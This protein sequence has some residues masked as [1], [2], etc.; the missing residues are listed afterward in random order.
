MQTQCNADRI[1]SSHHGRREVTG[2]FDGGRLSSDGGA[3]LPVE[4]DLLTGLTS[5][6]ADCF[7]DHRD[8]DR[9][10]HGLRCPVA[11]RVMGTALGYGDI[12]DHD[13]PPGDSAL[14]LA[15]GRDGVTGDG[16]RRESDRGAPLAG[17]STPSRLEPG[18]P[19]RAADDRYRRMAADPAATGRL[20]PGMFLEARGA[21]PEGIV[22]GP[23]ATDDPL[24]GRQECRFLHGHCGHYC[25]LPLYVT[26]GGHVPFARL[27]PSD[28][29]ASDGALEE[30]ARIVAVIRGAWPSVR[31]T[32]RGDSGFRRDGIMAWCGASGVD[33]VFGLARSPRLERR[34]GRRMRRP[35]SRCV[36]TGEP[37]RRFTGFGYRTLPAW[38]RSRRV[39]A[40]AG[41]L[42]GPRGDSPRLTVTSLPGPE[43]GSR[44]LYEDLH[45]ARGDMENRIR[46]R[47]LELFAGRTST[48]AMRASQLRV[49]LSAFAGMLVRTVRAVGLAGT[50]LAGARPGTIRARLLKVASQLRV[51]VRRIRLSLSPVHPCRGLFRRAVAAMRLAAAARASRWPHRRPP[52]PPEPRAGE[53]GHGRAAPAAPEGARGGTVVRHMF[54][55]PQ[56][57]TACG[58]RRRGGAG[59]SRRRTGPDDRPDRCRM[60]GLPVW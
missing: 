44:A 28:I 19:D 37:S 38:S 56:P 33:S 18:E 49:Y 55:L 20:M 9:T 57:P 58:R 53:A 21:P 16:R 6:L 17:S 35:R 40:R 4:A 45:C 3:P 10:G 2:A 32:V 47:R 43:S 26:C 39:V 50:D 13:I 59:R 1:D 41:A 46:E 60:P 15:L 25:C 27:R 29:D 14:A 8:P 12:N 24:H 22:P 30:L 51:G 5:G 11:Q 23:A 34:T 54:P 36:A 52:E 31:I 42:P 48:A 7:T